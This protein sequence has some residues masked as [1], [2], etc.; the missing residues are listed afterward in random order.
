MPWLVPSVAY[1]ISS[2][3]IGKTLEGA[4][5]RDESR[6][7][8][9]RGERDASDRRPLSSGFGRRGS[10]TSSN[11]EE[12]QE[13]EDKIC[14]LSWSDIKMCIK[15]RNNI[16]LKQNSMALQIAKGFPSSPLPHTTTPPGVATPVQIPI[17]TP[18]VAPVQANP[19]NN[20]VP[21]QAH[22][23]GVQGVQAPQQGQAQGG[24]QGQGAIVINPPAFQLG[25]APG[26]HGGWLKRR[27][28]LEVRL[29]P[30]TWPRTGHHVF[31]VS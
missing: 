30:P 8:V 6:A 15:G 12:G 17:Q 3:D 7:R 28:G 9:P 4:E 22:V 20:G 26:G 14:R 24:A 19:F 18:N 11:G 10:V 27:E 2:H 31:L 5:W 16:L 29:R 25:Q 21:A 23:Q 13:Q 1:C